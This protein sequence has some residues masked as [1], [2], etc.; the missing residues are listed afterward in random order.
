[1]SPRRLACAVALLAVPASVLGA[2]SCGLTVTSPSGRVAAPGALTLGGTLTVQCTKAADSPLA[3]ASFSITVGSTHALGAEDSA[4]RHIGYG[5]WQDAAARTPW[6][7]TAPYAISGSVVFAGRPMAS[8]QLPF[9]LVAPARARRPAAGSYRDTLLVTLAYHAE[10]SAAMARVSTGTSPASGSTTTGGVTL[11]VP[12]ACSLSTPSA[13]TLDYAAFQPEPAI[14]T[15]SFTAD[16]NTDYT[17][18][19]DSGGDT[20]LGLPYTLTLD[21]VSGTGN[22]QVHEHHVTGRIAAGLAGACAAA[23]CQAA[24]VHVL[25]ISY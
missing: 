20:L 24:R 16:C 17:L 23:P 19:L 25:T 10:G 12:P 11:D 3:S 9:Y 15:N 21:A 1:V 14:A 5:L 6:G 18:A 2:V 13:V 4:G 22:G 7:S 8:T